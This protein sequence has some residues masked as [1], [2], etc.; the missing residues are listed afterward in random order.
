MIALFVG[1]WLSWGFSL[2]IRQIQYV[3]RNQVQ[4]EGKMFGRAIMLGAF[5]WV[6]Y[7]AFAL[8]LV[9]FLH[10]TGIDPLP[11]TAPIL[12]NP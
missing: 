4:Y 12:Q 6:A 5:G 3:R 8:T 9:L 11:E 1:F 10:L 7:V 2:G